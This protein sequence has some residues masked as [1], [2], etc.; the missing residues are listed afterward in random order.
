[1]RRDLRDR[2][3]AARLR[4]GKKLTPEIPYR[5]KD[6]DLAKAA[7]I[8]CV[9]SLFEHISLIKPGSLITLVFYSDAQPNAILA[10]VEGTHPF[11]LRTADDQAAQLKS[12]RKV[13]LV[14]Q[15]GP[16]LLRA[17]AHIEH[18]VDSSNGWRIE[19]GFLRWEQ[20][21]RR[22][23]PRYNIELPVAIRA[24]QEEEDGTA[25]VRLFQGTSVDVGL[26]GAWVTMQELPEQG[27][28]VEFSS[29]LPSGDAV[30]ALAIV[31]HACPERQGV[32]LEFLDYIGG[33]RYHLHNFLSKAS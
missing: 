12:I 2:G 24:I 9:D 18:C 3:L 7:D 22:R 32:G 21:D 27:S 5:K 17:E 10:T 15:E 19:V 30:R 23:H 29:D 31:V 1:M 4:K 16:K 26:G 6:A 8:T 20:V 25:I 11:V 14:S 33:A 13:M 28:L